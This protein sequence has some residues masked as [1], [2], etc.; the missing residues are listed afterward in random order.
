V[1]A[2]HNDRAAVRVEPGGFEPDLFENL[3][4]VEDHLFWSVTR[5]RMIATLVKQITAQLPNGYHVLEVG[6]GTGNVLRALD[7]ACPAGIVVGMD[8][9]NEGLRYARRRTS[10]PLVQGDIHNLPFRPGFDLVGVFDVLEHLPDDTRALNDLRHLLSAG[11]RLIL[12]VPAHQKLWSYYDEAM[13]HCRRYE[14][15]DLRHKL[16]SAGYSVDYL[17][18]FM[19]ATLPFVWMGRRVAPLMRR[20]S[21]PGTDRSHE[22]T[23]GEL[24]VL[25]GANALLKLLLLPEVHAIAHR[26]SIPTGSSLVAICRGA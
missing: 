17:T 4:D 24:R 8:L 12:T 25:P 2:P 10:C 7:G 16:E 1:T 9:F 18:Y 26:R 15:A 5:N 22:L 13:Q 21:A 11:G 14:A 19:L 20:R 3:Y 23:K 6:C